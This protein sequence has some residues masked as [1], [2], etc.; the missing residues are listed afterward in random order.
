MD[1]KYD[2]RNLTLPSSDK[3]EIWGMLK[4]LSEEKESDKVQ[5]KARRML[6]SLYPIAVSPE[7]SRVIRAVQIL[8]MIEKETGEKSFDAI[9][10]QSK[11]L[12]IR[13]LIRCM[14]D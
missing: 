11:S 5:S 8:S 10:S 2:L 6:S 4:Q 13:E 9:S 7:E 3:L 12:A 14:K 1:E